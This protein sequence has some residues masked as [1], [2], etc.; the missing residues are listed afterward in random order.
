MEKRKSQKK[1]IGR[2]A[3]KLLKQGITKQEVFVELVDKY[4]YSK[5][6]AE[7]LKGIPSQVR[8]KKYGGWNTLLLSLL[9]IIEL[10]ILLSL[11]PSV[12]LLWYGL[13]IYAVATKKIKYYGWITFLAI[14]GALA[15]LIGIFFATGVISLISLIL[16]VVFFLP[17][18][19][20]PIWLEKRLCPPPTERKELYTNAEGEQRLRIVYEFN[21]GELPDQTQ[22]STSGILDSDF[23]KT[24]AGVKTK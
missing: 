15:S 7:V 9:I 21:D 4:K 11:K 20:L 18:C 14:L 24:S 1:E 19:I 23:V 8:I 10:I 6:V 13:L 5:D 12:S 22:D 17:S 3:R 2:E 16:F